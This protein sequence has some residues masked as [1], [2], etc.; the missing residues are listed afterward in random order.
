ML[1][2]P[3]Y[4]LVEAGRRY[5]PKLVFSLAARFATG[6]ELDRNHFSGGRDAPA[7]KVLEKLGFEIATKDLISPLITKFLEQATAGNELSVRG[8]LEEYRGLQVRVSFGQGNFARIPWIS[9][10]ARV[11]QSPTASIPS[12]SS[13]ASRTFFLCYGISETKEPEHLGKMRRGRHQPSKT[14]L[15]R[16]LHVARTLWTITSPCLLQLDSTSDARSPPEFDALIDRVRGAPW[17][18]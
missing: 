10:L 13:F 18:T 4:D 1:S 15:G 11:K 14:G 7:F 6:Q 9:F 5:P 3:G 16:T 2:R 8:Y 17:P 12:F